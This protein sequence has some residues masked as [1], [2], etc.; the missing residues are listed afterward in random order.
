MNPYQ[1]P[2]VLKMYRCSVCAEETPFLCVGC[3]SSPYCSIECFELDYPLHKLLC[4]QFISRNVAHNCGGTS[5]Q[6]I[7]FPDTSDKPYFLRLS[8]DWSTGG[9]LQ[10]TI[11]GPLGEGDVRVVHI[12]QQK[13]GQFP[14]LPNPMRIYYI[15][16]SRRCVNNSIM[17]V[18]GGQ[19]P[20]LWTGPV[21]AVMEPELCQKLDM[22]AFRTLCDFFRSCIPSGNPHL[23]SAASFKKIKA[24]RINGRGF[25]SQS[26]SPDRPFRPVGILPAHPVFSATVSCDLPAMAGLAL[27]IHRY[28]IKFYPGELE[29][30]LV[31]KIICCGDITS[32][33]WGQTPSPWKGNRN[34]ALVARQDGKD[35]LPQH[36]EALCAWC[37]TYLEE[38]RSMDAVKKATT[39]ESEGL[40]NCQ[41]MIQQAA[42]ESFE[43][44]WMVFSE[45]KALIDEN[46]KNIASPYEVEDIQA[47]TDEATKIPQDESYV[48]LKDEAYTIV[49]NEA[50]VV[51]KDEFKNEVDEMV[52]DRGDV[53]IYEDV[54]SASIKTVLN[55]KADATVDHQTR[56]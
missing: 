1:Q 22:P 19:A 9:Y 4:L 15:E 33:E 16:D 43:K 24:V 26:E 37:P 2:P 31:K 20:Y 28:D 51:V 5:T 53:I 30:K 45:K 32:K 35:L 49:K 18:T 54:N 25:H 11:D 56:K 23:T 52:K 14:G 38:V 50:N 10:S 46:W 36:V 55:D 48:T 42:R 8:T 6:G 29:N 7:L 47:A 3:E 40:E 13:E 44:Y 41:R 27:Y 17:R 39:E 12:S 34:A 21:L